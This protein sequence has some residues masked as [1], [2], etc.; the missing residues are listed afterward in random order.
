MSTPSNG[1][2]GHGIAN[3]PSAWY[4]VGGHIDSARAVISSA[5]DYFGTMPMADPMRS[6]HIASLI[7]A[8]SELLR[9]AQQDVD[10]LE[11]ELKAVAPAGVPEH[12]RTQQ[13]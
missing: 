12:H 3:V 11:Q 13:E 8:A 5:A 1:V 6:N 10:R 7:E 4:D 9:L 2:K